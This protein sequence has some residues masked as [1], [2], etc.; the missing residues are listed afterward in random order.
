MFESG[1]PKEFLSDVQYVG[2]FILLA[3]YNN[4]RIPETGEQSIWILPNDETISFPYRIYY[5]DNLSEKA[6]NL[7]PT[8]QIIYHC[9]FSRSCDGFVREKHI[10]TLL[11]SETPIWA[12]PYVIKACDEYVIE[13]LE[14]VYSNLKDSDTFAYKL[15]CRKNQQV[16]LRSYNRMVSYWNEYYRN[17]YYNFY[18][19]VGLKLFRDCFGYNRSLDNKGSKEQDYESK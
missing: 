19:Y 14:T 5:K 1:F 10:K 15:I 3:S 16:F 2:E 9:I 12:L 4:R 8:Q 13:I 6:N 7:T 17:Q 18:G 11:N